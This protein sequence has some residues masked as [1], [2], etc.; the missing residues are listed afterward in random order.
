MRLNIDIRQ[1]IIKAVFVFVTFLFIIQIFGTTIIQ[2]VAAS[3]TAL[4]STTTPNILVNN[5]CNTYIK[6]QTTAVV[7]TGENS[8]IKS[9]GSSY[10]LTGNATLVSQV[11]NQAC[12]SDIKISSQPN[13][14]SDSEE[15]RQLRIE[16]L[17]NNNAEVENQTTTVGN[18]GK[19][20][21]S[22]NTND[23]SILTGNAG[24]VSYLSNQ[25]GISDIGI[26]FTSDY[27][28][29]SEEIRQNIIKAINSNN[30]SVK[31]F[32]KA[33][34]NTGDNYVDQNSGFTRILTG[35]SSLEF[36]SDTLLNTFYLDLYSR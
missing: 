36:L 27:N 19:N 33:V 9:T 23:S 29:D 3:E 11:V 2:A 5:Y 21:A 25:V 22:K 31:S 24:Q 28:I 10:V 4:F 34:S 1:F 13:Y 35:N 12:N 15:I 20:I 18:T 7:N 30:S 14:F 32:N 17:N 16:V 8:I 6:N 26:E